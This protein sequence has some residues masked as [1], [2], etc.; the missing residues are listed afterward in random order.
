MAVV[1][2]VAAVPDIDFDGDGHEVEIGVR[3]LE[4]GF[5]TMGKNLNILPGFMVYAPFI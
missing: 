5:V 4:S 2:P 1:F 3:Y